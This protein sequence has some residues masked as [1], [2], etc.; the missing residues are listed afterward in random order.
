[1]VDPRGSG[2]LF[3]MCIRPQPYT[4]LGIEWLTQGCGSGLITAVSILK[5]RFAQFTLIPFYCV[6]FLLG[7]E[8]AFKRPTPRARALA[9]PRKMNFFG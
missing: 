8:C 4:C 5:A 7:C 1:M 6:M 3:F 2:L 9:D